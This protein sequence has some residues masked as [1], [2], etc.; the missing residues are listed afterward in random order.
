[1]QGFVLSLRTIKNQDL[2]LRVLTSGGIVE[3]YRFYG[4]RHSVLS[5]GKKID[6]EIHHD[7]MFLPKLRNVLE[8]GYSWERE[9]VRVYVWQFFINLLSDHLRDVV[10][11]E[12]FYF[13]FLNH[14]AHRL[15]KQNPMRVVLEMGAELLAYE[16]R[17]TRLHDNKCFVCEEQLKDE[18]SLGRAFLSAHPEC[19]GGRCFQ[20]PKISLF[21]DSCS[22]LNLDDRE[23]DEL[24]HILSLGL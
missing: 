18:V 19:I 6:F 10:Y 20:K 2:I 12:E 14:G 24:W 9:Y 13:D 15:I 5:V 11:L 23:V 17:N 22:T 8:L 4:L 16:G 21:L 7:G 1:M 3:L